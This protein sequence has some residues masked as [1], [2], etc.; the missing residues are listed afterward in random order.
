MQAAAAAFQPVTRPRAAANRCLLP[1]PRRLHSRQHSGR[2]WQP[3]RAQA[4]D[5]G[6]PPSTP[7]PPAA[8]GDGGGE[9]PPPASQPGGGDGPQIQTENLQLP[10]EVINRMRTTV[11]SFDSFFVTGVENYQA[12]EFSQ[13]RR[14]AAAALRMPGTCPL[15]L[16]SALGLRI[17]LPCWRYWKVSSAL[18]ERCA[19][20]LPAVAD[21]VL[22]QGNLRGEPAAAYQKL[23]TRLKVHPL[24]CHAMPSS[25]PSCLP[26]GLPGQAPARPPP[27]PAI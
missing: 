18:A 24:P 13:Q 1:L 4:D 12:S 5:D 23:T 19:L 27:V 14:C 11:F 3:C 9:Q 2:S 16:V 21:G 26:A 25:Q 8:A 17:T 15:L 6:T 10:S 7:P 20:G 22:F